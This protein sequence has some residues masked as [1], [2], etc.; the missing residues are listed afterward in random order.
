M[1]SAAGWSSLVARRAHNPKVTGSNPVPA[2]KESPGQ[3]HNPT[4]ASLILGRILPDLSSICH[5]D[6]SQNFRGPEFL[7]SDDH[8]GFGRRAAITSYATDVGCLRR[9]CVRRDV[10][11]SAPTVIAA[12]G[13]HSCRGDPSIRLPSSCERWAPPFVRATAI[14]ASVQPEGQLECG[15]PYQKG[16]SSLNGAS[17]LA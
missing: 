1:I 5:R 3:D 14:T 11:E 13:T 8:Q 9:H 10:D 2:T 17:W 6:S 15:S 4:R 12:I 16:Q 7:S